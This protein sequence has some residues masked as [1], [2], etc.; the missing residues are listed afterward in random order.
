MERGLVCTLSPK[1]SAYPEVVVSEEEEVSDDVLAELL[2]GLGLA[3]ARPVR[4][5][6]GR[7]LA[8]FLAL[9][10]AL[11]L[12][13]AL[14]VL[15]LARAF[16]FGTTSAGSLLSEL[17]VSC[18]DPH[19]VGGGIRLLALFREGGIEARHEKENSNSQLDAKCYPE[20]VIRLHPSWTCSQNKP[21]P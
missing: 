3:L 15:C 12:A 6:L 1:T 13:L 8:A 11:A 18:S 20:H 10:L 17:S 21:C 4:C 14:A 5:P 7:A 16:A 9:G 19:P 2:V